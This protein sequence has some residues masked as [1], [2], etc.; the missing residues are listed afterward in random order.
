MCEAW[1]HTTIF[2]HWVAEG[3]LRSHATTAS[4]R[5][6]PHP[7]P[8]VCSIALNILEH[9]PT[10]IATFTFVDNSVC[11]TLADESTTASCTSDRG[12]IRSVAVSVA[13]R[14]IENAGCRLWHEGECLLTP[15]V[16]IAKQLV[17]A[18]LKAALQRY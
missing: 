1:T 3:I 15:S 14:S 18:V 4:V 17:V 11:P 8:F 9:S 12:A 6:A 7:S 13:F 16:V 5:A 10:H 2:K